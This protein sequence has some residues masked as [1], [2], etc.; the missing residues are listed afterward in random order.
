M[1]VVLSTSPCRRLAPISRGTAPDL[2]GAL[3]AVSVVRMAVALW[4]S[5][6]TRLKDRSVMAALASMKRAMCGAAPPVGLL[7]DAGAEF[8]GLGVGAL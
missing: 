2:P 5:G 6:T 4:A 7:A 8:Y 1:P 3:P